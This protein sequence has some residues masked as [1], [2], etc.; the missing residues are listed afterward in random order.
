MSPAGDLDTLEAGVLPISAVPLEIGIEGSW[1]PFSGTFESV[2]PVPG[3]SWTSLVAEFGE[4]DLEEAGAVDDRVYL[5]LPADTPQRIRDLAIEIAGG[6]GSP[7]E[8]SKAIESY[9]E[10]EYELALVAHGES[11]VL[12]PEGADPVDWF[13]FEQRSGS[14][15]AFSSAF[16]VLARAAGVPARVV[17]G[18]AISPTPERQI[19]HGRQ[20]HQWA[21]IALEDFGWTTIDPTPDVQLALAGASGAG[22]D[23]EGP[24]LPSREGAGGQGDTGMSPQGPPNQ[25]EGAVSPWEDIALENLAF[26]TDPEVRADAAILLGEIASIRAF[27]ALAKAS[28]SDPDEGVREAAAAGLSLADF[29]LLEWILRE[30]PDPDLRRAAAAGLG[31]KGDPRALSPLTEALGGDASPDV[32]EAVATALVDLGM[33]GALP[34]LK[35]A[36][37]GDADSSVRSAAAGAIGELGDSE[38]VA[39]L[40][41]SLAA[42]LSA[43]VRQAVA[44]ALGQI[45]GEEAARSLGRSLLKDREASVRVASA[46]AL[47]E[48]REP[49]ALPELVQAREGDRSGEVRSAA[50]NALEAYSLS[51]LADSLGGSESVPVRTSAAEL[52]G[53]R[54]NPVA[55][56][57]LIEAM[58]DQ[59]AEVREAAS[60]AIE[61]LG[62]LTPLENGS[63]LLAHT[64][65]V[66]FVPGT[67]AQQASQLPHT[68]VFVVSGAG[69]LDFLRTAVGDQYVGGQWL[70][71]EQAEVKYRGGDLVIG[72]GRPTQVTAYAASMW[73]DTLS[74]YPPEGEGRIPRGT[75]PVSLHIKELSISGTLHY[76]AGTFASDRQVP[77]YEWDAS[78]PSFSETQLDAAQ[79]SRSYP[80]AAFPGELPDRIQALARRITDGLESPYQMAKAIEQY[81]KNNYTYRLADSS[82]EGVP[83]GEDPVDWFLFESREGTCGNFSSAFVLM[84]RSV[85]LPA[86]VV[87]GWAITPDYSEQT[88]YADQAH[89][90]AEVAFEGL[91][92]IQFEPT[93]SGGPIDRTPEPEEIQQQQLQEESEEFQQLSDHLASEDPTDRERA[94]QRL[95][96]VGAELTET[97]TGG[98]LVTRGGEVVG[99]AAGTTT[100]QV[101]KGE[102]VPVFMVSGAANT[103]Y[104]RTAVGDIYED[105]A[106]RQLDSLSLPYE[107]HSS[108]P[109]LVRSAVSGTGGRAV[110]GQCRLCSAER[111]RGGPSA[112]VDRYD[113][114]EPGLRG[115]KHFRRVSA[116]L[117]VP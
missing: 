102:P 30:H 69:E 105:G 37:S 16:V 103:R 70:R 19:V 50:S 79:P 85:G 64:S 23:N 38:D 32:R 7:Y 12:P 96:G 11:F 14:A 67:T 113:P 83:P 4:S 66:S 77:Y 116:N 26:S 94:E 72:P 97:E 39:S 112:G 28:S 89:Q 54:G 76:H 36:L 8:K 87:S 10:S 88:V 74:I 55:A 62:N 78:V 48:A 60:R 98:R 49:R 58:N 84:A 13:L 86:R 53:E 25:N 99:M 22:S 45:G 75:V 56:P 95:E 17:S 114:G 29:D 92:W 63:G 57:D 15:T 93:A 100:A 68:P 34:S 91:G 31:H 40:S 108:I 80:H 2:G 51:E 90:Q 104:I 35:E 61:N 27:E 9:L 6:I 1:R 65:G 59:S 115:K 46:D 73:N 111:I 101:T 47:S 20:T 81:L 42:D 52:L 110:R 106:W 21:E 117:H 41:S 82:S 24:G 44:E 18:W 5:T 33:D 71:D 107:S 109:H 3:Y 43:L